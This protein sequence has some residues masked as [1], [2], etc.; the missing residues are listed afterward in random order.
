L[1][2]DVVDLRKSLKG[3]AADGSD[4]AGTP[5]SKP[6]DIVDHTRQLWREGLKNSSANG[7][8]ESDD[9]R[10]R[11]RDRDDDPEAEG[12]KVPISQRLGKVRRDDGRSSDKGGGGGD[13]SS[14]KGGGGSGSGGKVTVT[15]NL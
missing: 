13:K 1:K 15:V 4:E 9:V 12:G 2:E 14:R 5:G 6:K 7:D 10:K 3:G 8:K 11:R